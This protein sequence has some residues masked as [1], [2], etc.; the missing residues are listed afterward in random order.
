MPV[1]HFP[2]EK[3][4]RQIITT[5]TPK[6]LALAKGS[7]TLAKCLKCSKHRATVCLL[8]GT[9]PPIALCSVTEHHGVPFVDVRLFPGSLTK[10]TFGKLL[11]AILK[12][13]KT[14]SFM[15]QFKKVTAKVGIPPR[16]GKK[17]GKGAGYL[18]YWKKAAGKWTRAGKP[19]LPWGIAGR[20]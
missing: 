13:E 17:G 3:G 2:D 6:L 9:V 15:A 14:Q 1:L 5:H 11:R 19:Y 16:P 18:I 7:E 8:V 4:Y 12:E 20:I 10:E